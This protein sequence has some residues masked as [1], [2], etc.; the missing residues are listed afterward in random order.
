MNVMNHSTSATY[1][2]SREIC[3][4]KKRIPTAAIL[5]ALLPVLGCTAPELNPP[6]SPAS[7]TSSPTMTRKT[8]AA[9]AGGLAIA[10]A[11]VGTA[12]GVVA[13]D[14]KSRFDKNP[15]VARAS[16]GN[17]NAVYS[18][19]AFGAAVLLGVTSLVLFVTA[20]ESLPGSG[21]SP[22][23][24]APSPVAKDTTAVT[25]T[26]APILVPHGGGAGALLRF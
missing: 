22:V 6:A 18:D 1:E 14:D 16:A 4:V 3:P 21:A 12:F 8:V 23:A 5:A 9:V 7:A 13:L 25:F 26:A 17:D 15:T 11:G 2:D 19:T 10:G 20:D 24:S